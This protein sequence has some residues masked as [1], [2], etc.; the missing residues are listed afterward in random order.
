[1]YTIN[2]VAQLFDISA[3]TLRFYDKEGLLPFVSRNKSGNRTFS[4][5]DLEMIKLICCLKNTGMPIKE[6]KRYVDMFMHGIE[7]A[8]SRKQMM[9]DHR[10]EVLRQIDD[11]KKNL[12]LID[13]KITYYES[14]GIHST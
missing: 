4:D 2:Q 9:K 14:D 12:N 5:R 8:A 6:I 3:H 11:L 13:L 10:R 7:T 1:M